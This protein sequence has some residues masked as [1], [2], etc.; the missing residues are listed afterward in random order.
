MLNFAVGIKN[1][2]INVKANAFMN[3]VNLSSS[4]LEDPGV[5]GLHNG[6]TLQNTGEI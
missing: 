6:E 5:N 4:R 3:F 2:S 1:N